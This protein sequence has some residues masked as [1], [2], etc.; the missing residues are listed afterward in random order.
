[1]GLKS[2]CPQ[3]CAPSGGPRENPLP[4]FFPLCWDC[5]PSLACDPLLLPSLYYLISLGAIVLPAT[6]SV[7]FFKNDL[8]WMISSLEC[9]IGGVITKGDISSV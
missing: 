3:D 2:R 9:L 1:M 8:I 7:L 5:P 4:C 6:S